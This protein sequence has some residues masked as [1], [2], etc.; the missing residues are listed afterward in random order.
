MIRVFLCISD[1]AM[2]KEIIDS[3]SEQDMV[4]LVG[5]STA[6]PEDTET[7]AL[8]KAD[9]LV[10]Q[11]SID[12]SKAEELMKKIDED[13]TLQYLR[14]IHIFKELD[15]ETVH[16][17]IQNE[18]DHYL[19]E[20]YTSKQLLRLITLEA[21]KKILDVG[22]D[23]NMECF[24]SQI[25]QN[26]AVPIHLNGFEYIKTAAI[27]LFD[28]GGNCHKTMKYVYAETARKHKTTASRVEKSI[29][30]AVNHAYRTQ[31]KLI[32]IY[33]KKPTNAQI[34]GIVREKLKFY[35]TSEC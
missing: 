12:F 25:L 20:P 5:I 22:R 19:I 28:C 8:L 21:E 29:R 7:V 27:I 34:V 9:V 1:F 14:I 16:T 13:E 26:M 3:R 17:L 24:A 32:C 4:E 10:L 31:P 35:K 33:K 18:I 23:H 6:I 2:I 30:T 11:N 15:S